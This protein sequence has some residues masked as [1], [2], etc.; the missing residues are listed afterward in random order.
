VVATLIVLRGLKNSECWCEAGIGN[1]NFRGHT[2]ACRAARALV[3]LLE[4]EGVPKGS[5][6]RGRE[7]P[8]SKPVENPPKKG[9]PE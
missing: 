9:G 3:T 5:G 8:A 4:A 6:E 1:L 2:Q 7:N